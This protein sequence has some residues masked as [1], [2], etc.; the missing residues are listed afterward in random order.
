MTMMVDSLQVGL[1]LGPG[2]ELQQH[3]TSPLTASTATWKR[4]D[5][6]AIIWEG[7][8]PNDSKHITYASCTSEVCRSPT[9]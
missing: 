7:D 8:D 6:T 9:C 1:D 5:Q 3:R 4:G 2:A